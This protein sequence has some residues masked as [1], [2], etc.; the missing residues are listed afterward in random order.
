MCGNLLQEDTEKKTFSV[1]FANPE[2]D[3]TML[4]YSIIKDDLKLY[5]LGS[6]FYLKVNISPRG[7]SI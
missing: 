7:T 1:I 3:S 6:V 5:S 2:V 4:V